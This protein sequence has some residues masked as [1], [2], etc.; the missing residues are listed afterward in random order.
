MKL[1]NSAEK[2]LKYPTVEAVLFQHLLL[3]QKL[4]AVDEYNPSKINRVK[5]TIQTN[6]FEFTG[7]WVFEGKATLTEKGMLITVVPYLK[8]PPFQPLNIAP[9]T[10][11]D[12]IEQVIFLA[13]SILNTAQ[14]SDGYNLRRNQYISID[15]NIAKAPPSINCQ[16]KLPFTAE[17]GEHGNL[18]FQPTEIVYGKLQSL[19][20]LNLPQQYS[21]PESA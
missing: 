6:F 10:S 1:G 2:S 19:D 12:C 15:V 17:V 14:F 13:S 18:I 7:S 9:F 16:F 5:G 8:S 21:A 3:A 11:A 4:E 20:E